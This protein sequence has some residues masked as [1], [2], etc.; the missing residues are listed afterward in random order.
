M[1]AVWIVVL[2]VFGALVLVLAYGC[3]MFRRKYLNDKP[4]S[5]SGEIEAY[6]KM[7]SKNPPGD[8]KPLFVGSSVMR[9]WKTLE[10][11]LSPLPALNRAISGSKIVQWPFY[12][13]KL[14][15]PY[16]PSAVALYAGSNDMHGE[17]SKTPR[18]I[19]EAFERFE[20]GVHEALPGTKVWFL[21]ILPSPSKARWE[22][23]ERI[24]EADFLIKAYT[25]AGMNLGFI[26]ATEAFLKDGGPR[27]E[28]FLA[29]GV[30]L[31]ARGYAEWAKVI[32][33]AF[34]L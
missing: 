11:D 23:W 31:N 5:F 12:V 28:L 9:R 13:E 25:D 26:N 8:G 27:P 7:D 20:K 24:R 32:R 18:Q 2:S 17:R 14:V 21:S 10:A 22:N 6:R 33:A 15:L 16:R 34:G 1:P 19:L 3:V 29:D 30:H 4:E